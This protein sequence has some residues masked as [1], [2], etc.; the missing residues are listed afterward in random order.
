MKF[1]EREGNGPEAK[2]GNTPAGTL[3]LD[4]KRPRYIGGRLVMLNARLF[5]YCNASTSPARRARRS[6]N[7]MGCFSPGDCETVWEL[8]KNG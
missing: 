3:Y 4:Q 1:L 2:Y 5:K 6:T 7:G 8:A